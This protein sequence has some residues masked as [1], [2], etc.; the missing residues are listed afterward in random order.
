M[1]KSLQH[2]VILKEVEEKHTY[3]GIV[4]PANISVNKTMFAKIIAL[5]DTSLD[6][7]QLQVGQIV[8][9]G[10]SPLW[11]NKYLHIIDNEKYYIINEYAILGIIHDNN[12]LELLNINEENK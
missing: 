8:L 1:L 9:L 11:E 6:T 4:L 2:N 3:N 7:K 5:P 12:I 10:Y